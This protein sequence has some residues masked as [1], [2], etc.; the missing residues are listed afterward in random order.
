[1]YKELYKGEVVEFDITND[2]TKFVCKHNKYHTI[3]KVTQNYKNH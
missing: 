3:S 1:M 2:L